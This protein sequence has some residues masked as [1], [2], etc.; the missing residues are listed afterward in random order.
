MNGM[1]IA[2]N[3]IHVLRTCNLP[4]GERM[5]WVS[6]WLIITRSCVFTMTLLSA[7]IGILLAARDGSTDWLNALLVVAGL[8]LAHAA[9]NMVN[10]FFDVRVGVDT[11][12][13]PR[14]SYAPHPILDQL[15]SKKGLVGAILLCN[16]ADL[17]IAI[18]LSLSSGWIVMAFAVAGLFLSVAY[19]APPFQLKARG[20][21]EVAIFLIWGPLMTVGTYTVLAGRAPWSIWLCS[22]P[23]GLA[24]T[25][26]I[27]GKHL[28]KADMDAQ[29][30]VRSLPVVLGRHKALLLT[31]MLV[32]GFY[33]VIVFL[34]GASFL[35]G[36]CVLALV[37][38]PKATRFQV[39]LRQDM[40]LTPAEAFDR[41][42]DCIPR[43]LRE[44]FD[45]SREASE[46]PLWPLW[47]VVWSIWWVRQAG[48]WFL[49]GLLVGCWV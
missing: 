10:D 25:T 36:A 17:A 9:N 34:V 15:V 43:D 2:K 47:Y 23:Y 44:Q 12:D 4:E 48:G 46:Y 22:I 41:S 18:Q 39:T 16:V 13:Y 40:P 7:G 33:L 1:R 26:A 35:P 14:A 30:G 6:R 27:M 8:V 38:L 28:D 3:W 11:E 45:P 49:L 21:G 20:L 19:V 37:S 29:K 42:Y 24:V 31:E 32:W 5:D